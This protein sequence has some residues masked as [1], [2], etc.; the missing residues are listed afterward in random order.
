M[1]TVTW[2]RFA[3]SSARNGKGICPL[4]RTA[5]PCHTVAM[6]TLREFGSSIRRTLLGTLNPRGRATRLDILFWLIM[7]APISIAL[8]TPNALMPAGSRGVV[9]R[10][11]LE[12]V[13][14]TPFFALF[15]RR[16]H[17]QDRTGWWALLLPPLVATSIYDKLRVNLH[18]FDP[19]WPDHG[20]WNIAL[21]ACAVGYLLLMLLPGI[22]GANRH[23][24]DP[25]SRD[26]PV[27]S[28]L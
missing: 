27:G 4:S 26:E 18:P 10:C 17:D 24:P 9:A 21:L 13:W 2:L 16:M 23:G 12:L 5:N 25:R 3:F 11:I 28:S 6:G 8:D 15:A 7:Y 14:I 20:S 19:L 22:R 1:V